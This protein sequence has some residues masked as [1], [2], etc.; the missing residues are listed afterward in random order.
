MKSKRKK[1]EYVLSDDSTTNPSVGHDGDDGS[2]GDGKGDD[3]SY[4]VGGSGVGG[5]EM[6]DWR[7]TGG[8]QF[9]RATQDSDNDAPQPQWET[10]N[11]RR[12]RF[13]FLLKMDP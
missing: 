4:G 12:R 8:S 1:D 10:R 11:N 2:H 7:F 6:G 3:G 5:S 13:H 9:I